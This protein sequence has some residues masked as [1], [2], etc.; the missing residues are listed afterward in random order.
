M[1]IMQKILFLIG[2]IGACHKSA[3]GALAEAFQLKYPGQ[4]ETPVIDLY[5]YGNSADSM[6]TSEEF[7]KLLSKNEYLEAF[8]NA[9]I[10]VGNN[11]PA[12]QITV[13]Y[14]KSMLTKAAREI[15][16]RE[17]PKIVIST[18][19][20]PSIIA[21]TLKK[22]FE[23]ELITIVPDLGNFFRGWADKSSDMI[24]APSE[25]A[26]ST[27]VDY[28]Y[29]KEQIISPYFALK[30]S[31]GNCAPRDEVLKHL[32]FELDKRT[33]LIT[34]GGVGTSSMTG[35]IQ[36]LSEY[37]ELQ[38]IIATGKLD[39]LKEELAHK[40]QDE[41]QIKVIGFVNNINDYMNAADLVI[42]KPGAATTVEL[43]ALNKRV[44]MTK[45]IGAQE[46]GNL[47]YALKNP[48][49]RYLGDNYYLLPTLLQELLYYPT[50]EMLAHKPRRNF[51]ESLEMVEMIK[52]RFLKD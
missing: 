16:E 9:N 50:A 23:F 31:L 47:K 18:H 11:F 35:L 13:Q 6:I 30:P 14:L 12:Y 29:P 24:F 45:K 27:L 49:M 36:L 26:V 7:L 2:D 52:E 41:Q 1:T 43:E 19:P 17:Q 8:N 10:A 42:S 33:I 28:G 25:E 44:L 3:A 4:F 22:E 51:N 34:G 40:Y 5:E 48:N 37:N 38:L 20:I 15:I 46:K 21:G 39:D 32:G